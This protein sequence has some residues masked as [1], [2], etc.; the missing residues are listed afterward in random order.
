V[1]TFDG[2]AYNPVAVTI[3]RIRWQLPY[4]N[5]R[6]SLDRG[7]DDSIHYR[8]QRKAGWGGSETAHCEVNYKPQG[9]VAAARPD[10]LEFFLVE[11]Y[12]LYSQGH[13][14]SL[15]RG[16]VHHAPYP[17]QPAHY[18]SL[19]DTLVAA[20]GIK[21]PEIP[22]LAHYARGVDVEIFPLGRL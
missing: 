8:S 6:I 7:K 15:W 3:A 13:G 1:D 19:S 22:A 17:L 14:G 5:A 21:R 4:F 18:D 16:Q 2:D 12:L 11:R 9:P 20:A 10:T